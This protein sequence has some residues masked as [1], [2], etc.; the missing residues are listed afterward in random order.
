MTLLTHTIWVLSN[1]EEHNG[2]CI[3]NMKNV[4]ILIMKYYYY[5]KNRFIKKLLC[6][7]YVPEHITEYN[8]IKTKHHALL[9]IDKSLINLLLSLLI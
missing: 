5:S 6:H 7:L 4:L 3:R 8:G 2:S 9:K 1:I